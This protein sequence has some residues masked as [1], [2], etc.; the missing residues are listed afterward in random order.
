MGNEMEPEIEITLADLTQGK[1][2]IR[3]IVVKSENPN[4]DGKTFS[5][6]ALTGEE[7]VV[8]MRNAGLSG[9]QDPAE[10][11]QFIIEVGKL[12]VTTP[13]IGKV[14]GK[15]PK[16]VIEQVG[17][18]IANISKPQEKAVESFPEKQ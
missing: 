17:S 10:S 14:F 4:Y 6:R 13:G 8:A 9:N 3:K 15:F 18:A 16:E 12:G 7:W 11:F 5:Y 1:D 2:Y